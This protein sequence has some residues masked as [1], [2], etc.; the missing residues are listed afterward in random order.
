MLSDAADGKPK[1]ILLATGSEVGLAMDAKT[2]LTDEGIAVR[3][4]SMPCTGLY[5]RQD[6]AYKAAL[7]PDAVPKVS[8]EAGVTDGWWKYVGPNGCAIG[9][10]TFGESAPGGALFKFFGFTVEHVVATVRKVLA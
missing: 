2:R 7:L 1:V 4:V 8:I 5:D 3:V 10:D 9:I 6:A